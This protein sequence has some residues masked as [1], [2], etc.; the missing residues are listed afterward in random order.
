MQMYALLRRLGPFVGFGAGA[1]V[2]A[3]LLIVS[4]PSTGV[5]LAAPATVIE[6]SFGYRVDLPP[7]WRRSDL[8]SLRIDN[9]QVHLGH[10]VYTVRSPDDERNSVGR[11]G[12]VGPA[13]NYALVIEAWRNPTRLSAVQWASSTDHAG[14]AK[15]QSVQQV[16][17]AGR[18][19]ARLQ[20]GARYTVAYFVPDGDRM[21][22]LGYHTDL[23][24]APAGANAQGLQGII[25]SFRFGP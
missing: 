4:S 24:P 18:D 9:N 20:F 15:G 14:W 22:L 11:V 17:V 8:L 6:S 2:V 7:G 23:G 12:Q 25:A 21:F 5:A 19:A 3:A 16:R 13:W 1:F 10:D